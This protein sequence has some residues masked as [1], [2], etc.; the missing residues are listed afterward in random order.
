MQIL[1]DLQFSK[2][3]RQHPTMATTH[4][5]KLFLS[6]VYVNIVIF[7]HAFN[8]SIKLNNSHLGA[9]GISVSIT[10][11]HVNTTNNIWHIDPS[12]QDG[13]DIELNMQSEWGFHPLIPS[14][15]TL[16]IDGSTPDITKLDGELLILF[17]V[18]NQYYF[19][20]VI[21]LEDNS[22]W[23][24]YPD[25]QNKS[26][27]FTDDIFMDLIASSTDDR[28]NRISNND[29]W[30]NIEFPHLY[31]IGLKWPLKLSIT[32][33]PIQNTT[34]F[35][36]FVENRILR[37]QYKTCFPVDQGMNVYLMNDASDGK[38]FDIFSID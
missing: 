25:F 19:S 1:S 14:T 11:N 21:R 29:Q 32:N 9:S 35:Q 15:I 2:L 4:S 24:S 23:K 3:F 8:K 6:F 18:A 27:A 5:L 12:T 37:G 28:W 16:I 38:P 17:G 33:D 10:A 31:K 22:A 34:S 7:I 26:L 20:L 30:T 13:T 36:L